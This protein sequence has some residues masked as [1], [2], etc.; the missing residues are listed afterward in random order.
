M[1]ATDSA[2]VSC[3]KKKGKGRRK[4]AI[5]DVVR[6]GE[7]EDNNVFSVNFCFS[8]KAIEIQRPKTSPV[9]I[10][11]EC[12]AVI[13][14]ATMQFE[15]TYGSDFTWDE[16][17]VN[18]PVGEEKNTPS[19][20]ITCLVVS[21]DKVG[22]QLMMK[23]A[24]ASNQTVK[25]T[26][27]VQ[28]S[29]TMPTA[30]GVEFGRFEV[31]NSR[32]DEQNSILEKLDIK[33]TDQNSKLEKLEIEMREQRSILEKISAQTTF[34]VQCVRANQRLHLRKFIDQIRVKISRVLNKVPVV[35]NNNNWW[36]SFLS[37]VLSS[38]EHLEKIGLTDKA[39]ETIRDYNKDRKLNEVVAFSI[40]AEEIALAIAAMAEEASEEKELFQT[41]LF[42]MLF[43]GLTVDDAI[44]DALG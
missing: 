37:D 5:V 13:T 9:Y 18:F 29:I 15:E 44:Y 7:D 8:E 23:E 30:E 38:P 2:I 24:A 20:V 11:E 16:P 40:S 21:N 34:M 39:V 19:P 26:K 32:I 31:L 14:L 10:G 43:D 41:V 42:P 33:I 17:I 28:K 6:K 25:K 12:K 22:R 36:F 3:N 4:K 35:G 1:I 27:N